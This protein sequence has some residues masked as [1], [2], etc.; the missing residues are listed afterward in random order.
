M[1][2]KGGGNTALLGLSLEVMMMH[3]VL[4]VDDNPVERE[5]LR[6]FWKR[7]R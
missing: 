1:T 6:V 4:I 3:K 7:S 2:G 5:F